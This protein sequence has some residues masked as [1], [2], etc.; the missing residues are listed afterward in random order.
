M[1][2]IVLNY[3]RFIQTPNEFNSLIRNV[4]KSL[5]LLIDEYPDFYS[6]Y[7]N[8][9]ISGLKSGNRT[10]IIKQVNNEI[11][12]IAILK[13]HFSEK[14]I[15]AF[16]VIEKFQDLGIGTTL[17]K[18]SMNVLN[19]VHP[20]ITVSELR[21]EQFN[22]ILNKF[23]FQLNS[24]NHDYYKQGITEF[25]FNGPIENILQKKEITKNRLKC[26]MI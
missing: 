5:E 15:S 21:I 20:K 12:G 1:Q 17:M 22:K 11:A 4:Y 8:K 16:R 25:S 14:K 18:E 19:T 13:D 2:T 6:W 3:R 10:I 26:E 23:D 7:F 9:V 24:S